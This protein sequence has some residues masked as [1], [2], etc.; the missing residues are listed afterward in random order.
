MWLLF[1]VLVLMLVGSLALHHTAPRSSAALFSP[2][3][4][5]HFLQASLLKML[6]LSGA[7]LGLSPLLM[8]LTSSYSSDTIWALTFS[9][10]VVHV[11][12]HD[13]TKRDPVEAS[14]FQSTISL[15]AAIFA[16]VLL[17]SRLNSAEPVFAFMLFSFLL[18]AGFPVVAIHV[19]CAS[20]PVSLPTFCTRT[21]T[22]AWFSFMLIALVGTTLV[23]ITFW[24]LS[25]W[26]RRC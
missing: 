19:R 21:R 5:W 3:R 20:F 2:S 24:S 22:Q 6:L 8:T 14:T 25:R 26:S 9:L 16:S 15:N 18:F 11:V 10:F 17:A 7:L 4:F 1:L 23:N 13:Y 12:F